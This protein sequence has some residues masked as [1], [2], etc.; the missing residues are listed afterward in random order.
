MDTSSIA[1][2]SSPVWLLW[3]AV[4]R[5]QHDLLLAA[6]PGCWEPQKQPTR[7]LWVFEYSHPWKVDF[8]LQAQVKLQAQLLGRLLPMS[9]MC[10][11]QLHTSAQS[12]MLVN[13]CIAFGIL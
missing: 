10:P 5:A 2:R 6:G 3:P 8:A 4:I 12:C 13:P 1:A 7:R 11:E 9:Q